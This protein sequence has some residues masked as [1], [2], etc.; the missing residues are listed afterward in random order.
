M[1]AV[2]AVCG[3]AGTAAAVDVSPPPFLQWFESSY[4]AMINR[5]PDLFM[6][7]YGAVWTPPP[8]RG[9]TGDHTVGYDV[10]DRFDLGQWDK[11][12]LYGTETGIKRTA[13]MFHRA[14]LDLHVD[15]VLN[16]NGF[17]DLATPGFYEAGGYPGLNITLPTDI[18]GD[19]HSA[20]WGGPEY[21][22]LAGLIDIAHEKNHQFIRSPVDPSD[23][24]NIRA[25]TVPAFGRLANVPD[26]DNRRFY[27]DVGHNTIYVYDPMTGE[28]DIPVHQFNLDNPMDG[29][30]TVE[31]AMG[32]LMRNAQWLVQ[33]IGVDGL[34][35]DA[36]KHVQ[37]FTLDYIDRAVYRQNPRSLL[38]GTPKHVFSYSEVF[39]GDPAVLH[40]HVK[41]TIDPD[42]PGRIGGNRDTLDFKLYFALKEN[43]E[44]GTQPAWDNWD[45]KRNAWYAIK[46]AELD[47]SP[48]NGQG[49]RLHNGNAGVTFIQSHDV[50]KPYQ[51]A[52]VAQAYTLMMP[53]NT[54][55][56]F[57]GKE[58]GDGREFPK[59]GRGDALSVKNGSPLTR[60]LEIRNSHGRGDYA[61]R[62][63]DNEGLFAFERGG[64]AIVL[65]SNRTDAGFHSRTLQHVGFAPGTYLL[66]LT[67]H[68][69]D[70]DFDPF[71]DFPEVLEVFQDGGINKVNLRFP[72]NT[73]PDGDWHNRGY[74][75]YGLPT[76]RAPA[77]LELSDVDSVLPGNGNPDSDYENGM[78]RQTDLHVIAAD[79][80]Q[81]RLQ[82][83]QVYLLGTMHDVWA[84][85]DNALLRLDGGRDLNGNDGV[86]FTTPGTVTYGFESF[87]DKSSPW[88]GPG[89]VG[90]PTW[91]GDGEFL[92]T[93]DTTQLQEGVHFL[94]AR[95]FR[96]RTDGGPAVFSSFKKVIYVD[97][98]PPVSGIRQLR[99]VQGQDPGD[100]DVIAESLDHTADN[101]H[102]LLNLPETVTDQQVYD[103]IGQGHQAAERKD[104]N[105][106][107]Q[108]FPG[109]PKGNNVL[110]LV[111]YEISGASN[112]QRLVGQW[113]DGRGAGLGDLNHDGSCGPGDMA[114]TGYGFEHVL[115]TQNG[116]FNPAG[117]VTADGRVDN[118]DLFAL[119]AVLAASGASQN[120]L[121]AYDAMLL[122]RGD[123]TGDFGTNQWDIDEL[124]RRFSSREWFDDLTGD[125]TTNQDDVDVLVR[126]ILDTDY[127]DADLDTS[128]N[129]VDADVM[130]ANWETGAA[131]GDEWNEGDFNGDTAVNAVDAGFAIA[132][133]TA[134]PGTADPGTATAQYDARSGGM[135]V[136]VNGVVN[137]Y[138]QSLSGGFTG[139][140]PSGLA[141]E[142]RMLT[143]NDFQIGETTFFSGI[144]YADLDLGLVSQTGLAESDIAIWYQTNLGDPLTAGTVHYLPEPDAMVLL[145]IG[146]LGLALRPVRGTVPFHGSPRPLVYYLFGPV[147]IQ[148]GDDRKRERYSADPP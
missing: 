51:L 25:G 70:P 110:T 35:I 28:E 20:Y 89:G 138:I 91:D 96:H 137:W 50:H 17:S 124:Y 58:F 77:G 82:T 99:A 39:D 139:D 2:M 131:P 132:N 49:D 67:G 54:A 14:G 68:A 24:R 104:V 75:I 29:D 118:H 111:T 83:E 143:D 147:P 123:F 59:D 97:R 78:N 52:D 88:I 9:D 21:E 122:R 144:S 71:N 64:S 112:V 128:V 76:P 134:D 84:D 136:T 98:L 60:L 73:A 34:R 130:I 86:D 57:N 102:V 133:W 142:G 40:P 120:T 95:A 36:A 109:I 129:G 117:D 107:K 116:E 4:E 45:E 55:V 27:P 101:V 106:F 145:L 79:S 146:L 16:H 38:D 33:V 140:P 12:T 108:Y 148:Y 22:R 7:G 114:G 11:R 105:V 93:V 13:T 31:N 8:G 41:K 87:G 37:G 119:E 127:G 125:G 19:F 81:V 92:Q 141:E 48:A 100:T 1:L 23:P 10:Y 42:S 115:Y 121:D 3:L 80:F 113:V 15:F 6:A 30:A 47:V 61:E 72:T 90:D 26:P 94:E 65:L 44:H 85:G 5:T 63:V 53:G 62:W 56:Y 18:D 126:Q 66:E 135:I 69:A 46:D 43:L 103:L 32:Y 74:L